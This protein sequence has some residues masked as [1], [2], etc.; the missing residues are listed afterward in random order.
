MFLRRYASISLMPVFF[1]SSCVRFFC[2]PVKLLTEM[3][4]WYS[5]AAKYTKTGIS[6][7][8]ELF[9]LKFSSCSFLGVHFTISAH[10]CTEGISALLCVRQHSQ[11]PQSKGEPSLLAWYVRC[12]HTGERHRVSCRALSDFQH[13]TIL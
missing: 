7:Y 12:E 6:V 10:V 5:K 1:S 11:A 9:L 2:R 8:R 3:K 4:Y 13:L